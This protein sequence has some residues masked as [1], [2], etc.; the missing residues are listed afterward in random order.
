[1][2]EENSNADMDTV[3]AD[4][5]AKGENETQDLEKNGKKL[6]SSGLLFQNSKQNEQINVEGAQ[7]SLRNVLS[8]PMTGLLMDDAMVAQCGHSFGLRSLQH[9]LETS[10]CMSCGAVVPPE[11]LIPNY[12]LRAAVEAIQKE[13]FLSHTVHSRSIRQEQHVRRDVVGFKIGTNASLAE[14]N[15]SDDSDDDGCHQVGGQGTFSVNDRIIIKGNKETPEHLFCQEA[16]ITAKCL[17]GWYTVMT[18]DSE[19][20]VRLHHHSLQKVGENEKTFDFES[21][22]SPGQLRDTRQQTDTLDAG[23]ALHDKSNWELF[24]VNRKKH[25]IVEKEK[26]HSAQTS[27][28][29]SHEIP[30]DQDESECLGTHVY[31]YECENSEGDKGAGRSEGGPTKSNQ[32]KGGEICF[33]ID[34]FSPGDASG[35]SEGHMN[36]G[37]TSKVKRGRGKD[38]PHAEEIIGTQAGLDVFTVR[39][40]RSSLVTRA[41]SVTRNGSLSPSGT[42]G[43]VYIS[44]TRRRACTGNGTAY[45]TVIDNSRE[46]SCPMSRETKVAEDLNCD[47]SNP[48]T[49][50]MEVLHMIKK[51]MANLEK[52]IPWICFQR[53]WR[54]QR[55]IW[56]KGLK[57]SSTFQ[58]LSI[59]LQE[60][61]SSLLL[62]S[63]GGM[64]D[65]EWEQQLNTAKDS[66]NAD[67]LIDLWRNL[68][69]DVSKWMTAK[70]NRSEVH[71]NKRI[72]A[73]EYA[74]LKRLFPTLIIEGFSPVGVTAAAA[75]A[76]AEAFSHD[77][78][79][80]TEVL[81]KVPMKLI[82]QHNY[83]DLIVLREAL[84][85]EKRH[86]SAKLA[87]LDTKEF[88]KMNDFGDSSSDNTMDKK[89]TFSKNYLHTSLGSIMSH[90]LHETHKNTTPEETRPH[91]DPAQCKSGENINS[92]TKYK[93]S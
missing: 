2:E 86:I 80:N 64:P 32:D 89:P 44:G 24:E 33:G 58:D 49:I 17:D 93:K 63:A 74:D 73:D 79:K 52:E 47:G 23:K 6:A 43:K 34:H 15:C 42:Y 51:G 38:D 36:V 10:L 55:S 41:S 48:G 13:D 31:G 25:E 46:V 14:L 22:T 71:L 21:G 92:G 77:G 26:R 50:Q 54:R 9:V 29:S 78:S 56:R 66:E 83:H 82:R 27:S 87:V 85:R 91:I 20:S 30:A 57:E 37:E 75:I 76:A 60:L 7:P 81:L 45:L 68:N 5:D 70:T 88:I 16:V 69:D 40:K 61:R 4:D 84:E 1:M 28:N 90:P 12:A 72:E 11:T 65:E 53:M 3:M 39:S 67:L 62:S 8:D 18:L 19:E 59:R 35:H